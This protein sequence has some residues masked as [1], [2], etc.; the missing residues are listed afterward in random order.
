MSGAVGA[1]DFVLHFL[2]RGKQ[3]VLP[4]CCDHLFG[5]GDRRNP[6]V[7]ALPPLPQSAALEEYDVSQGMSQVPQRYPQFQ[8]LI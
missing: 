7:L 5:T 3:P 2:L 6:W 4:E 8:I 1:C